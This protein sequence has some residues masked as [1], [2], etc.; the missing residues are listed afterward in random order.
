VAFRGKALIAIWNDIV[1]AARADFI[2]WHNREH[3]FDR[4]SIP[5]F[6]SGYRYKAVSG[7]PEY[8][9]LYEVESIGLATGPEYLSRLNDPTAWTKR[10]LQSYRNL[11][12]SLCEVVYSRGWGRGGYLNSLRFD[13]RPGMAEV[14]R[15]HLA[16]TALPPLYEMAGVT[17]LHLGI[18][19]R[20]A[21][22][23][24]SEEKKDHPVE[25]PSWIVIVEA[26]SAAAAAGACERLIDAGLRQVGAAD[27]MK[28]NLYAIEFACRREEL[29]Q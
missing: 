12:R 13:A 21:S 17:G 20:D 27:D 14:L 3:I 25:I 23:I 22:S 4:L 16:E 8:F 9:T 1:D 10:T 18:A 29:M 2:E 15:R 11:S 5:G 26:T 7:A 24:Q 28:S 6:L 19:D